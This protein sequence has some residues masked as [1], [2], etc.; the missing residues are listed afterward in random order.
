[1][2]TPN[3]SSSIT[4]L[5]AAIGPRYEYMP[6]SPLRLALTTSICPPARCNWPLFRVYALLPAA[7]GPRSEYMPSSP[8]HVRLRVHTHTDIHA[9]AHC[10]VK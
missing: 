8:L 2:S 10:L 4:L 3:S 7:I 5:P 9:T 6:S 1:M